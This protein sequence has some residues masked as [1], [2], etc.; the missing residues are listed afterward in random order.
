MAAKCQF[1]R[2]QKRLYVCRLFG[3]V[4]VKCVFHACFE[5]ILKMGLVIIGEP[6]EV[7]HG[8]DQVEGSDTGEGLL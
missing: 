8:K 5:C 4:F 6:Q 7:D 3:D 1:C 2:Q